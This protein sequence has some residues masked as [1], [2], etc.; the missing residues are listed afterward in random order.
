M[1]LLCVILLIYATALCYCTDL[2]YGAIIIS[3]SDHCA[4][5]PY[6]VLSDQG[7]NFPEER[8]SSYQS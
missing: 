1:L 4:A 7:R 5:T 2:C 8:Y 6:L 3:C